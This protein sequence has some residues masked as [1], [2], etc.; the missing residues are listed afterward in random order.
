MRH[1][2]TIAYGAD[3]RLSAD[4]FCLNCGHNLRG[5]LPSALCGECGTPL[6]WSLHGSPLN[7][8]DPEWLDRVRG[9]VALVSLML[10]W[11]WLPPAWLVIAFGL[12]HLLSPTPPGLHAQEFLAAHAPRA[13]AALVAVIVAVLL[14][15][16]WIGTT[17]LPTPIYAALSRE[18]LISA[19]TMLFSLVLL[20]VALRLRQ[21]GRYG[22]ARGLRWLCVLVFGAGLIAAPSW[23]FLTLGAVESASQT[24]TQATYRL[25]PIAVLGAAALL[26]ALAL[27]CLALIIVW[28]LLQVAEV[29]ASALR[30]EVKVWQGPVPGETWRRAQSRAPLPPAVANTAAG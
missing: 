26:P 20:L 11:V 14:T 4:L 19:A 25:E 2:P 30:T 29:R 1:P 27:L 24:G 10:V 7:L 18:A 5:L 15:F 12:W 23:G 3:G 22:R 9:G 16:C 21:I 13:V 28:R 17:G 8:A 6:K